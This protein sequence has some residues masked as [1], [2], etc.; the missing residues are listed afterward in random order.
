MSSVRVCVRAS[1]CELN[2]KLQE[3]GF[4]ADNDSSGCED[5]GSGPNA[6][7]APP[8]ARPAEDLWI[9]GLSHAHVELPACFPPQAQ[10]RTAPPFTIIDI[11]HWMRLMHISQQAH[12]RLQCTYLWPSESSGCRISLQ[13]WLQFYF[14]AFH[15]DPSSINKVCVTSFFHSACFTL[16]FS[17]QFFLLL[18][19]GGK[20][21]QSSHWQ[22][23]PHLPVYL[24][25]SSQD[26]KSNPDSSSIRKK[27]KKAGRRQTKL[28]S[29][30]Y[31]ERLSPKKN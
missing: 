17:K 31:K 16:N 18:F 2:L 23:K 6:A 21:A 4:L 28:L 27:K 1:V 19:F 14:F 8:L 22:S 11:V 3:P 12:Q 10:R 29:I 7:A 9:K 13:S 26:L 24:P 20:L 5:D 30:A 25:T 15:S